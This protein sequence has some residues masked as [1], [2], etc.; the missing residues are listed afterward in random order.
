MSTRLISPPG[1]WT[2]T[3]LRTSSP[4]LA[5]YVLSSLSITPVLTPD[6]SQ[7]KGK[8][9]KAK[10]G[11]KGK[12]GAAIKAK[13]EAAIAKAKAAKAAKAKGAAAAPAAVAARSLEDDEVRS[14]SFSLPL[15]I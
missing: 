15:S 3:S 1:S 11:K 7:K 14:S 6:R 13:I 9:K 5:P 8:G 2:T 10:K 12:K 4:V